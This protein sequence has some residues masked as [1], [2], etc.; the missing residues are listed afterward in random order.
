MISKGDGEESQQVIVVFYDFE[1]CNVIVMSCDVM[2]CH[3]MSC[4]TKC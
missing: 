2:S 1:L 3:V 4:C